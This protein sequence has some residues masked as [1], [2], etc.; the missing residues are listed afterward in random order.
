MLGDD[1]STA[2]DCTF[3]YTV[4]GVLLCEEPYLR[5]ISKWEMVNCGTYL[6][7]EWRENDEN[8]Y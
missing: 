7:V 5:A 1:I 8:D 6:E 2:P 3:C 4:V